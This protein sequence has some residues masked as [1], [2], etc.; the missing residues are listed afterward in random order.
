MRKLAGRLRYALKGAIG[1]GIIGD[2]VWSPAAQSWRDGVID[3]VRT[4]Q[5]K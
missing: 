1:G 4:G 2:T 5:G 3:N